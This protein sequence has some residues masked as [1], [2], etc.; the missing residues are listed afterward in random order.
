MNIGIYG[1]GRMGANMARRLIRGGI[2]VVVSNRSPGPIAELAG[3]GAVGASS[4]ED[5]VGKLDSPRTVW[6]MVPAGAVTDAALDSVT[7]LLETGDIVIDGGN[8]NYKDSIRRGEALSSQGLRFLDVGTSGGIWGLERGYSMMIGGDRSAFDHIE[9]V[10][11]TL[12][13]G[14]D[15]GYGYVGPTGAGHFTKMVHNG[16]EYGMMQAMAEGFEIMHKKTDLGL[17]L[18]AV[19]RIWQHGSV[20][21]SWLLDLAVAALDDD[22]DLSGLEA[23]VEDSGEGR[24]TVLEAV[25]LDSAAPVITLSLLRR[26]RSR[27]PS[28]FSDRMLAALR[29]QFGGHAVK[30]RKQD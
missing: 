9:Q 23:Y 15:R 2:E 25:D 13:P 12:A 10:F 14:A 27:D 7:P 21:S 22:H 1:L 30:T 8:S 26:F 3:E 17:D 29:N 16:I 11:Q 5:L 6:L 19:G 4:I 20:V 28:P 18:A 24:W